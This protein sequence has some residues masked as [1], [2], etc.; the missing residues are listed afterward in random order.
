MDHRK[1]M[2][3]VKALQRLQRRSI[4]QPDIAEEQFRLLHLEHI[5]DALVELRDDALEDLLRRTEP[6]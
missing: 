1:I 2:E 4:R 6:A 5:I 3:Q